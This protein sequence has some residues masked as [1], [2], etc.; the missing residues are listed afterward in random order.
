MFIIVQ[1]LTI[2][3]II[4]SKTVNRHTLTYHK[5]INYIVKYS[6]LTPTEYLGPLYIHLEMGCDGH[7]FFFSKM[8]L[9]WIDIINDGKFI[10]N[11]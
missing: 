6:K 1:T 11:F 2:I 5:K 3:F 9:N 7:D 4:M 8:D 10:Q